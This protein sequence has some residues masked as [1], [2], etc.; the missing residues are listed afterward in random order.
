MSVFPPSERRLR[1]MRR[2][3]RQHL[4]AGC[5]LLATA[6]L[7]VPFRLTQI[8]T[9]RPLNGRRLMDTG[10]P[11]RACFFPTFG[12]FPSGVTTANHLS[13]SHPV[14][15]TLFSH[16]NS[17]LT[18]SFILKTPLCSSSRMPV[19]FISKTSNML[20]AVLH[21]VFHSYWHSYH[22]WHVLSTCFNWLEHASTSVF[23]SLYICTSCNITV[24]C[25][26]T[27]KSNS[28]GC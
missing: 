2:R 26:C 21:F 1:T 22:S 15:C 27:H 4:L 8:Q 16:P 3:R 9:D 13:P 7:L 5:G 18:S 25:L 12:L 10:T 17:N 23:H 24:R 6:G 19:C 20:L 11:L 14:L 28:T